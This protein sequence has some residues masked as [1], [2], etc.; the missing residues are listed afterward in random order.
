M[1]GCS[2]LDAHVLGTHVLGTHVLDAHVLDTLDSA[3]TTVTSYFRKMTRD[4]VGA[5]QTGINLV[6][7]IHFIHKNLKAI[8]LR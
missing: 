3:V 4:K 8:K 7:P 6:F 1:V 5:V 2:I